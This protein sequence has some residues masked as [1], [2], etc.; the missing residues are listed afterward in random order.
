MVRVLLFSSHFIYGGG[1]TPLI[2]AILGNFSLEVPGKM[3]R[4]ESLLKSLELR[5]SRCLLALSHLYRQTTSVRGMLGV[6]LIGTG[7]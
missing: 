7:T 3:V 5:M 2:S 6:I 4:S 1:K